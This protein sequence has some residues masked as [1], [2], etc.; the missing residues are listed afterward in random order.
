M[1][2]RYLRYAVRLNS[3]VRSRVKAFFGLRVFGNCFSFLASGNN[4]FGSKSRVQRRQLIACT[5]GNSTS[6]AWLRSVSVRHQGEFCRF[7]AR[8]GVFATGG[9]A[10]RARLA[11]SAAAWL[12]AVAAS[13]PRASACQPLAASSRLPFRRCF[14]AA[15]AGAPSDLSSDLTNRSSRNYFAPATAWQRKLATPLPALRSSA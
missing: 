14:D 5:P 3:G 9:S 2:R 11:T 13:A 4:C 7:A 10:C 1:P 12:A 6:D 8:S 15:C